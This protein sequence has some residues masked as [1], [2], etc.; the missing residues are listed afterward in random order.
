MN[1]LNKSILGL[2]KKVRAPRGRRGDDASGLTGSMY[3]IE[4][5][6]TALPC[7]VFVG[8][9]SGNL[10]ECVFTSVKKRCGCDSMPADQNIS[11]TERQAVGCHGRVEDEMVS[12]SAATTM[13]FQ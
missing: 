6:T 13:N 3:K 10:C 9:K 5:S 2:K 12:L 8:T 7:R 4:T 1:I 11:G